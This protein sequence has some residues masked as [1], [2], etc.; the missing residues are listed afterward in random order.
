MAVG[1]IHASPHPFRS[2]FTKYL[3]VPVTCKGSVSILGTHCRPP[4]TIQADSLPLASSE[5]R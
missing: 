2:L 4:G 3:C 1:V 5:R